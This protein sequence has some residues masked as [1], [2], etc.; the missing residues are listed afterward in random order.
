MYKMPC[1]VKAQ[2]DPPLQILL[3][4]CVSFDSNHLGE[5]LDETMNQPCVDV[6]PPPSFPNRPQVGGADQWSRARGTGDS[7]LLEDSLSPPASP[8]LI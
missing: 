5:R 4:K 2:W 7:S 8:W 3:L 6:T 1:R